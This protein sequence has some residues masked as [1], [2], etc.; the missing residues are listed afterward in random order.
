MPRE[1]QIIICCKNANMKDITQG[2]GDERHYYCSKCKS[3]FYKG[4]MYDK[5]E[6]ETYI[7]ET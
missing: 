6:W 1:L 3:H 5:E 7:N 4:K 2:Q